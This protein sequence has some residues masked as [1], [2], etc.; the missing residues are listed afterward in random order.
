MRSVYFQT[1]LPTPRGPQDGLLA[2]EQEQLQSIAAVFKQYIASVPD[3][4][5]ILSGHAD[6]RGP[7]E[8]NQAL[9][10]R[11]VQLA[12]NYLTEQ[13]V[14]AANIETKGYGMEQNLTADQVKQ[15]LEQNPNMTEEDR[16][17]EQWRMGTLVLANNRRVDITLS[18]T[19]Q[20]SLRQYPYKAA[21]FAQLIDR[22]KP[23]PS[24]GQLAAKKDKD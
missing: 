10:E 2:S 24:E 7:G 21:D 11:R 16:K 20:E 5:L 23:N 13:G 6:K 1:D 14:P 22:N 18:T 12:K 19:G 17:A 8:Y 4:H 3:A 9:S 15:L